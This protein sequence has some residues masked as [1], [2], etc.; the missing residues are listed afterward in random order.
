MIYRIKLKLNSAVFCYT[1]NP[2]GRLADFR[3]A[4]PDITTIKKKFLAEISQIFSFRKNSRGR[5]A[6]L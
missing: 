4:H 3:F 5:Y 1:K 2:R 6:P